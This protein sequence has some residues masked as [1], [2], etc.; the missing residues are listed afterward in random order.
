MAYK[1][2]DEELVISAAMQKEAISALARQSEADAG[3]AFSVKRKLEKLTAKVA[4]ANSVTRTLVVDVSAAAVAQT[5]SEL[6]GL[7]ARALADW[8]M[9][10]AGESGHFAK[11][12]GF[13]SSLPVSALGASVYLIELATRSKKAM[14][15]AV[16]RD[17]AS[18]TANL[19]LNLGLANTVRAL[20]YHLSK[21]IDEDQAAESERN[22]LMSKVAELQKIL[23]LK[24]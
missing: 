17:I 13:Y 9:R 18:R 15:L 23:D 14:T 22:Q 8:S 21:S 11:N 4:E 24:K 19:L 5:V 10:T 3:V 20:R 7:G 1:R 12:I 2:K 16:G 6:T